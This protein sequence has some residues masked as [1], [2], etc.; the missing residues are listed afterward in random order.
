M[1]ILLANMDLRSLMDNILAKANNGIESIYPPSKDGGNSN[2]GNSN[3][4]ILINLNR[5]VALA[6]SKRWM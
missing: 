3:G 4:V 2:G 1:M 5:N 6:N